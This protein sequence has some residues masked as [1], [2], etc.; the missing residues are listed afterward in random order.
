MFLGDKVRGDLNDLL[1]NIGVRE[2]RWPGEFEVLGEGTGG[3]GDGRAV[4]LSS[5]M[6]NKAWVRDCDIMS[7]QR[8]DESVSSHVHLLMY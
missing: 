4:I 8:V 6:I 2:E 7:S 1:E 3:F 5:V